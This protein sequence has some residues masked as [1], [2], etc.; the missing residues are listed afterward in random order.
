MTAFADSSNLNACQAFNKLGLYPREAKSQF[1][2]ERQEAN[3]TYK[4]IS[5][6]PY[7]HPTGFIE[8]LV[9]KESKFSHGKDWN[10]NAKLI[11]P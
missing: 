10:S 4:W 11:A 3:V 7:S 8:K 2:R 6:V 5:S 1:L 9:E